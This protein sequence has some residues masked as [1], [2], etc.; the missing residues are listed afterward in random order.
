MDPC[1]L[2]IHQQQNLDFDVLAVHRTLC[3]GYPSYRARF[4][5]SGNHNCP[6]E[7]FFRLNETGLI[8]LAGDA[9]Q[10]ASR[11]TIDDKD[12]ID[13]LWGLAEN[14]ETGTVTFRQHFPDGRPDA[15]FFVTPFLVDAGIVTVTPANGNMPLSAVDKQILERQMRFSHDSFNEESA[16]FYWP[17]SSEP[18]LRKFLG[19]QVE[20]PLSKYDER[21]F[22]AARYLVFGH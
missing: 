17:D 2:H 21:R 1:L 9:G 16:R 14:L 7:A 4:A 15:Y 13:W 8:E 5:K 6:G 10:P 19:D 20:K 3:T 22:F 11:A 12:I 18:D